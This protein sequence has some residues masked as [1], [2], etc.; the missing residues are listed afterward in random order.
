M[1]LRLPFVDGSSPTKWTRDDLTIDPPNQ[2]GTVPVDSAKGLDAPA[3]PS[4]RLTVSERLALFRSLFRGRDDVFALRWEKEGK[5]GYAPQCSNKFVQGI[6]DIKNV[7][8]RSCTQS[9]YSRLTEEIIAEHLTGR[10]VV[11]IYPLLKDDT[12]WFLAIDF[13][14]DEWQRDVAAVRQTCK[15][16]GIPVYAERSRSG[17]GGHAR[18]FF[19]EPIAAVDARRLGNHVL[20]ETMMRCPNLSFASYDRLFPNQ[21]TMPKG[22]LGNLIALPLQGRSRAEGNSAF[23]DEEFRSYSGD[24]QWHQLAHVVRLTRTEVESIVQSAV[25]TGSAVGRT[26]MTV[27]FAEGA[28]WMG[29]PSGKPRAPVFTGPLPCKIVATLSQR[30]FVERTGIP[31]SLANHIRRLAAFQNPEFYRRQ[32]MRLALKQTPRIICVAEDTEH[33]V[34]L[35]RGCITDLAELAERSRI[36]LEISD[37]REEGVPIDVRFRERLTDIQADAVRAMEM[38]D[39]GVVVAPPG[40]GKTVIGIAL[41]ARRSRNT[42]VLV[43][44]RALL[45]Q[46]QA[47]IARFLGIEASDIGIV[48]GKK[49]TAKGRFVD[50][51]MLQSLIHD[52]IVDDLVQGYGHVIVDEYHHLPAVNFERIL[53]EV[54]A[55]YVTGLTA[56]PR[57]RD[58]HDPIMR[59]QL[60]PVRFKVSAKSQAARQPFRHLLF[61][62][63]TTFADPEGN[64]EPSISE[65]HRMLAADVARND[66]IVDDIIATI[67]EGRSPIVLTER[68]DHVEFLAGQLRRD[69]R[70]LFVL[71]G[72]A[73]EKSR[74]EITKQMKALGATEPRTIVATGKFVGEGFD[75]PRLDTL[76][77][78]LPVSWKGIV[79]Q[80]VGRLHRLHQDK[81]EVRVFDYV[82]RAVPRL[83]RMFEA[84][85]KSYR[86][87]GY[88]LSE[89]SDE[90]HLRADP[91]FCALDECADVDECFGPETDGGGPG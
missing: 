34:A 60:G 63:D 1:Q 90:F 46:W 43:H 2:P 61:A 83:C 31:P 50:V 57:R 69:A 56:T 73:S 88:E 54:K 64:C 67:R 80:Y 16:L 33:H 81:R 85:L 18:F 79:A 78:T 49:K 22:G 55:R 6:C 82:D 70:N 53:S 47:Q 12:C 77:L 74:R 20:T 29:R 15:T 35:P 86:A 23:I 24:Q 30:V 75:D 38:H 19:A 52:G 28:P 4:R 71:T 45:E 59:M 3:N 39:I 21:D 40:T 44:R 66:L 10:K 48:Q 89:L 8:C 17:K 65:I 25:Q 11:G 5:H 72:G 62:R 41:L 32:A 68:R 58:G 42:L 14:K 91:D 27:D 51:A 84:R 76:F 7:P 26:T 36:P 87:F 37:H 9:E 13:D